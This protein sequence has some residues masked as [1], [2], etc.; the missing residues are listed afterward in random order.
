LKNLKRQPGEKLISVMNTLAAS[1]ERLYRDYDE[2]EKKVMIDRIMFNG[3]WCFTAGETRRELEESLRTYTNQKKKPVWEE[4]YEGTL[5]SEERY[6][7][8]TMELA[9]ASANDRTVSCFNVDTRVG[10]VPDNVLPLVSSGYTQK[11]VN[12]RRDYWADA[13][14]PPQLTYRKR[15]QPS[16]EK[17]RSSSFVEWRNESK[18]NESQESESLS[19][20]ETETKDNRQV[21]DL[22]TEMDD[23]VSGLDRAFEN[24]VS[25]MPVEDIPQATGY[26]TKS[27]REVV[28]PKRLQVMKIDLLTAFVKREIEKEYELKKR[29]S[30]SKERGSNRESRKDKY[31]NSSNS[32]NKDK[33]NKKSKSRSKSKGDRKDN[34]KGSRK[35]SKSRSLSNRRDRKKTWSDSDFKANRGLGC[36]RDYDPK[37]EKRCLKCMTEDTHHEFQCKKFLR[38]SK[39]PCKNCKKGFHFAEECT[40]PPSRSKSR[41]KDKS[42]K[43]N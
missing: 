8:P 7:K 5:L 35:G 20:R 30:N 24:D 17:D 19:P 12:D 42:A 25:M 3:L 32:S 1:A 39:F 14:K 36:S 13:N 22:S 21:L 11:K 6:G 18:H 15:E 16:E 9:Y 40:E 28:P 38:R 31:E 33:D 37:R 41:D 2:V 23:L 26:T 34:S 10:Y 4:I 43:G 29:Q 27:G